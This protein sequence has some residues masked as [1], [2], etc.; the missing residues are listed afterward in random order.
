[1]MNDVAQPVTQR[2]DITGAWS[3]ATLLV[4]ESNDFTR[5]S[6]DR[7]DASV[8]ADRWPGRAR[9]DVRDPLTAT[10]P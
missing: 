7:G 5:V 8:H 10:E 2:Y 1:V 6:M 4:D 3:G 9:T